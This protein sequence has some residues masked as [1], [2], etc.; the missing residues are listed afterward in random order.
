MN[1]LREFQ[2]A[3]R[4]AV[5]SQPGG[6][7]EADFAPGNVPFSAGMAIYRNNV[8]AKLIDALGDLYPIIKRL[9]GDEFFA[10]A[11]RDFISAHLP[12]SPVLADYGDEFPAFIEGFGPAQSTPYLGDMACLE[13]AHHQATHAADATVLDTGAL[14]DVAAS[15]LSSIRFQ[16]H[17]SC[18]LLHSDYSLK[19]IWQAHNKDSDIEQLADIAPGE[20]RLLILRV[21]E[22]IEM[23]ELDPMEFDFITALMAGKILGVAFE[24]SGGDWNPQEILADLFG[25]GAV[26]N[27]NLSGGNYG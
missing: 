9:V 14:K 25:L 11:A 4:S 18:R 3:F 26:T 24:E 20:A 23:R 10:Y 12:R 27:I 13:L 6:L 7:G 2:N 22:R 5:L 21:E 15:A 8:F 1:T 17:P 19:E 16:F